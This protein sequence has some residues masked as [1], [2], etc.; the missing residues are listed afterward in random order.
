ML[1]LTKQDIINSFTMKHAIEAV[2]LA[3]SMYSSGKSQ[4][5]LRTNISVP[6]MQ[7]QSL[8]MP[9]YCEDMNNFGNKNCFY[10]SE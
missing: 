4:V 7:G 10:I 1:V 5:P 2:K 3:F 8:F 9:A 6:P